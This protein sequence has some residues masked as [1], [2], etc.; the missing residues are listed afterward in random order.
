M[1]EIEYPQSEPST[2]YRV[3]DQLWIDFRAENLS[4]DDKL[5]MIQGLRIILGYFS[6]VFRCNPFVVIEV[7]E[8][9]F[10]LCDFQP[11]GLTD[12]IVRWSAW[13]FELKIPETQITFDQKE[14]KYMFDFSLLHKK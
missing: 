11:E 13:A 14:N 6:D 10:S 2:G 4:E 3:G 12:A 9:G 5:R 7:E 1:A 8:V